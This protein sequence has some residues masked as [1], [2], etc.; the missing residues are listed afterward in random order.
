M[1]EIPIQKCSSVMLTAISPPRPVVAYASTG[2]KIRVRIIIDGEH[3][4][5]ECGEFVVV[6]I[7]SVTPIA[8]ETA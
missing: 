6:S 1:S 8:P 5:Y 7:H 3:K 2:Q 4:V